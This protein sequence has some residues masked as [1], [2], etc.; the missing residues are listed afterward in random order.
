MLDRLYTQFD[1]LAD[2]HGVYKLET[3]GDGLFT[4]RLISLCL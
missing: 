4:A 2:K 1:A 3:I